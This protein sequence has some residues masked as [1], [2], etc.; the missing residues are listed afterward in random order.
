[1]KPILST[2]VGIACLFAFQV[3][4]AAPKPAN[5]QPRV[6]SNSVL[7]LDAGNGRTLYNKNSQRRVPIAS[8]TKLMTAMVTLDAGLPMDEPIRISSAE[9]DRLKNTHSRMSVG[10]TLTRREML[11]LRITSYNVC[12]TKLLRSV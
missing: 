12:Y 7:V 10:T 4:H 6:E 1:M 3:G 9:V 8:I 11:L 5:P 2:L